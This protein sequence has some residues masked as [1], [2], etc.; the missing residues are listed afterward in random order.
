MKRGEKIKSFR[1]FDPCQS[2]PR[3]LV[4]ARS[5]TP[6]LDDDSLGNHEL[7]SF[8][9]VPPFFIRSPYQKGQTRTVRPS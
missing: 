3:T 4:I 9:N 8:H 6:L 2:R 1:P 7:V 5:D